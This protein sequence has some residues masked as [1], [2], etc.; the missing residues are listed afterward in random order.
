[1][2]ST[3][4]WSVFLPSQPFGDVQHIVSFKGLCHTKKWAHFLPP[5]ADRIE[6]GEWVQ[7]KV[8]KTERRWGKVHHFVR[9]YKQPDE[10]E[11]GHWHY[12]KSSSNAQFYAVLEVKDA[13]SSRLELILADRIVTWHDADV[14]SPPFGVLEVILVQFPV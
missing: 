7:F 6:P 1:M 13:D 10:D 14:V 5:K 11:S 9:R 2:I 3:K 4:T 12:K 8:N